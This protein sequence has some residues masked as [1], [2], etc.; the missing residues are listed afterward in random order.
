M[1][2]LYDPTASTKISADALAYGLR[3][4]LLQKHESWK[5]VAFT[6]Q[7]MSEMECQ[8]TQIEKEA[9]TTTWACK[10]FAD[11]IVGKHIKVETDHRR[12]VP[13]LGA[14]HLEVTR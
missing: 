13:L 5:P 9:L 12:L 14:K 3:A 11:F 8:Y 4:V 1:L 7:S 10:K 2:V 6:S